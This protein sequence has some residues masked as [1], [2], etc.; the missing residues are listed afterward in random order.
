MQMSQNL[1]KNIYAFLLNGNNINR[2]FYAGETMA[3]HNLNL[4]LGG[5]FRRIGRIAQKYWYAPVNCHY[6]F[7]G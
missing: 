3:A 2:S 5:I 7:K 4:D 1:D 6:E